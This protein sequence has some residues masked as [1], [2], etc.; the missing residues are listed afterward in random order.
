MTPNVY[1][2]TVNVN[3]LTENVNAI[4]ANATANVNGINRIIRCEKC[5]QTFTRK[6]NLKKHETSCNG[7][8]PL[9]CNT[10]LKFF[11]TRQGKY[12]HMKNVKCVHVENSPNI[13][14]HD[15]S[16]ENSPTTIINNN[17]IDNSVNNTINNNKT[18]NNNTVN[19]ITNNI[20]INFDH[21]SHAHIDI[22]KFKE[23]CRKA[24]SSLSVVEQYVKFTF[25]DPT[26]PENDN[27][28][29]TNLRPDNKFIDV[30]RDKWEKDLQS[31]V[32]RRIVGNSFI[33]TSD[34]LKDEDPEH[35]ANLDDDE[36]V[37]DNLKSYE[38]KT[39]WAKPNFKDRVHNTVKK[40]IYNHSVETDSNSDESN[41]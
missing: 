21:Y 40:C 32:I 15:D 24:L 10:C 34:I 20:I 4:D 26:H 13:I 35:I 39:I 16:V 33:F 37:V 23:Q 2:P 14:I 17:S 22:E 9:Q 7:L 8:D 5:N 3:A 30:Y 29:L 28:R 19:N 1:I 27:V 38:R 18:I 11:S 41:V 36:E 25:Q 12:Q 6:Y 31:T